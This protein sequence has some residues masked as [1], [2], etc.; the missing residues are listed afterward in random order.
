M[1]KGELYKTNVGTY[2]LIIDI[3]E[4]GKKILDEAERIG[5]YT[6]KKSVQVRYLGSAMQRRY[7]Y[8]AIEDMIRKGHWILIK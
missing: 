7:S 1:K 4:S 6:A 2:V 3:D 5:L 8:K